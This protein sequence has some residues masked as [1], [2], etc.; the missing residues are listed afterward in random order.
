MTET[1]Q[2]L[3]PSEVVVSRARRAPQEVLTMV[4]P[5][6]IVVPPNCRMQLEDIDELAESI[7][8]LGL[9]E[10]V[11]GRT[12]VLDGVERVVLTSGN[13]RLAA[14]MKSRKKERIPVLLKGEVTLGQMSLENLAHNVLR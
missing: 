11:C 8:K 12:I 7:A 9:L 2:E 5:E 4:E 14:W 13:R 10:P 6:S 3:V 1:V